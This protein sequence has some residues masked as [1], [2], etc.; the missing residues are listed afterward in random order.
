MLA[1]AEPNGSNYLCWSI[2]LIPGLL[3]FLSGGQHI[4][5]KQGSDFF[6]ILR[7]GWGLGYWGSRV[8][9]PMGGYIAWYFLQEQPKHSI[10]AAIAMGVGSEAVIRAKFYIGTN[11]L[12]DGTPQ[13]DLKGLFDLIAWWQKIALGKANIALASHKQKVVNDLTILETNFTKLYL[14]VKERSAS[15]D[16]DQRA[17]VIKKADQVFATFNAGG[18]AQ[19]PPD[20]QL[21]YSRLLG[22]GLLTL[23]GK[24]GLIL[25]TRKD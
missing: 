7:T 24:R 17:E 5:S 23:V 21:V 10:F 15:L 9:I 14:Q 25:F 2:L 20:A 18:G 4:Y 12:S 13:D 16:E 19:L 3:G 11:K 6:N 8:L 22:H 1:G